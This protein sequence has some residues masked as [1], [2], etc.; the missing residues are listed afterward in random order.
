MSVAFCIGVKGTCSSAVRF[1]LLL[2]D[3][4]A[5]STSETPGV[6]GE[7]VAGEVVADSALFAFGF[8]AGIVLKHSWR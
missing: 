2:L 7:G 5:G 3:P 4:S 1:F 6:L 8:G